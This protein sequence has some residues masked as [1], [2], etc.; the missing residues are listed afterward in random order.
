M[1]VSTLL[2]MS[3]GNRDV[4]Y[5]LAKKRKKK[6]KWV[7]S[8]RPQY[9]ALS[10]APATNARKWAARRHE[11]HRGNG[12]P[13]T[14]ALVAAVQRLAALIRLLD[15]EAD[16]AVRDERLPEGC[17]GVQELLEM[18]DKDG[19]GK[20]S[21][22]EWMAAMTE[23]MAA[24]ED[25]AIGTGDL[26]SIFTK[27]DPDNARE[28]EIV[29]FLK[30]FANKPT[31][32][33]LWLVRDHAEKKA[34]EVQKKAVA[35]KKAPLVYKPGV[36][37]TDSYERAL[38]ARV[39]QGEEERQLQKQQNEKEQQAWGSFQQAP[40]EGRPR[41]ATAPLAQR[42]AGRRLDFYKNHPGYQPYKNI[43]ESKYMQ[44]VDPHGLKS[45]TFGVEQLKGTAYQAS[46]TMESLNRKR[47][48]RKERKAKEE[49]NMEMLAKA[50]GVIGDAK[51]YALKL[52]LDRAI[53]AN[54]RKGAVKFT[55]ALSKLEETKKMATIGAQS[56]RCVG[57]G[58]RVHRRPH[59]A[60]PTVSGTQD[61]SRKFL[62]NSAAT[63][64]A[65]GQS[66]PRIAHTSTAHSKEVGQRRPQTAAASIQGNS[67]STSTSL[68]SCSSGNSTLATSTRK[69][70]RPLTFE[71]HSLA[72]MQNRNFKQVQREAL[73]RKMQAANDRHAPRNP[74]QL[75]WQNGGMENKADLMRVPVPA[76]RLKRRP[77]S[78]APVFRADC[79]GGVSMTVA[80]RRAH[81][82]S[83][84]R[85]REMKDRIRTGRPSVETGHAHAHAHTNEEEE[86][87]EEDEESLAVRAEM[88][89]QQKMMQRPRQVR[90]RPGSAPA[91][92]LY[93]A[94]CGH[95][96]FGACKHARHREEQLRIMSMMTVVDMEQAL[97]NLKISSTEISNEGGNRNKLAGKLAQVRIQKGM[98]L[99]V[100]IDEEE[101]ERAAQDFD[102][103]TQVQATNWCGDSD[104]LQMDAS[105]DAGSDESVKA[106]D[107]T[108]AGDAPLMTRMPKGT[109]LRRKSQIVPS[110]WGVIELS[111]EVGRCERENIRLG[112][113]P[114][115]DR[116]SVAEKIH[117]EFEAAEKV[118]L[119]AEAKAKKEAKAAAAA[120][121]EAEAKARAKAKARRKLLLGS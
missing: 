63:K 97:R 93:I 36:T 110:R 102:K 84:K 113:E 35:A 89:R 55:I 86:D 6:K 15:L 70:K 76:D 18:H 85:A 119:E 22:E 111:H 96:A 115:I 59:S 28:I 39:K 2:A 91:P 24:N 51:E 80:Q 54:D 45:V 11:H 120:K 101:A 8:K 17:A 49:R 20:L 69:P 73:L 48:A 32:L 7:Y 83:L 81:K 112:N 107:Q 33:E 92:Q 94:E 30:D 87:S 38:A 98:K 3:T 78:K 117:Q 67:R 25:K 121:A 65:A 56:S 114:Y 77:K 14:L 4:R 53:A 100:E 106:D 27:Y 43:R 29:T 16:N 61:S 118:R 5:D 37:F 66:R 99:Q 82:L 62:N 58:T 64:H 88:L 109:A 44:R 116:R 60:Q 95:I 34:K 57:T 41:P 21:R 40:E 74:T 90:V 13:S 1:P 79:E 23:L 12:G 108:E 75:P 26:Q 68:M 47:Q 9:S 71:E 42:G 46:V 19:D 31:A 52:R 105:G 10:S 103:R 72:Q 104:S 50:A